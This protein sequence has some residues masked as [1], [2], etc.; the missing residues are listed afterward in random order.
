MTPMGG[1]RRRAE[2]EDRQAKVRKY[3]ASPKLYRRQCALQRGRGAPKWR[4]GWHFAAAF[5]SG[6]TAHIPQGGRGFLLPCLHGFAPQ[7]RRSAAFGLRRCSRR[8]RGPEMVL[9]VPLMR[10]F[11]HAAGQ[12]VC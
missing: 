5:R 12:P 7:R 11:R 8:F 2:Q 6:I 3:G 9:R 4:K 10:L 1:G